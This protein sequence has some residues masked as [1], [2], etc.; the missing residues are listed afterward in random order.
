MTRALSGGAG[1]GEFNTVWIFAP[2]PV[3]TVAG[4]I[5]LVDA[6]QAV[7]TVVYAADSNDETAQYADWILPLTHPLEAWG[8][9]EQ[10]MEPTEFVSLR[11]MPCGVL[12]A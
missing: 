6:L 12:A 3:Y 5:R 9:C 8:T 2:N 11:S 1:Q 4:D 10:S 7:N